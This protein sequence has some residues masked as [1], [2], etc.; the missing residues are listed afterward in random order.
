MYEALLRAYGPQQW[1]PARTPF[2]MIIGAFLTQNTSWRAVER[3]LENLRNRHALSIDGLRGLSEEELRVLIR[4]SGYMIRKAGA[5][6]AFVAFV[7]S[8]CGGALE[9]LASTPTDDL[10]Q[11]LL[12]LPGVG[13][14]TADAILLYAFG[15]PVMVV[16][17]YF[18]RIAVRHGLAPERAAHRF[19]S[20]L[21]RA[22]FRDDPPPTLP[23]HLNEL[24]ALIVNVGK[25]HCG[26]SPRCHGCPLAVY[27]APIPRG[28]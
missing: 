18:R 26:P 25:L 24:H 11:R 14:E 22:A 1:W 9:A 17:E 19:L 15:H 28:F 10:R 21:G 8:E 5:L 23:A 13:P 16:D 6:K 7:D 27:P 4:P 20:Q 12:A 3:S 2:E